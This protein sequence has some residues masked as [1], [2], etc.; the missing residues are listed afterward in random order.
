MAIR[1]SV[2]KEYVPQKYTGETDPSTHIQ[3]CERSWLDVPEEEWVHQFIHTLDTVPRNWYTETELRKG[4][5]TW[6]LMINSFLL[7]FAFE[8]EHPSVAQ[9]LDIIK[10][11]IFRTVPSQC[12]L[13]LSGPSSCKPRLSAIISQQ[14]QTMKIRMR[15]R[16]LA[17]PTF[18]IQKGLTMLGDHS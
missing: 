3:A 4:T 2:D 10:I 13:N 18:Q 5:T 12:R 8:S 6:S 15:M 14:S 7:T 16:I 1:F 17:T 9:A 11:K